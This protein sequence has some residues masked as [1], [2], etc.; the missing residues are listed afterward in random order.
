MRG[1]REGGGGKKDRQREHQERQMEP[2]AEY[3]LQVSGGERGKT[4]PSDP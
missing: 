4:H 2:Y 3:K 1:E